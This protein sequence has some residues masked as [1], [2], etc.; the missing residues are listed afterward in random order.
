MAFTITQR[1]SN[2]NQTSSGESLTSSAFTPTANSRLFVIAVRMNDFHVIG[3]DWSISNTGS[4]SF[5]KLDESTGYP[6]NG[7]VNYVL[8]CVCWWDDIGGSPS[9]MTVTVQPDFSGGALHFISLIVF[10]VT[11]FDTGT[12][13]AQASVDNGSQKGGGDSESG[14]LTLGGSPTSGNLVV[15]MF[16]AGADTGGGFSTPTGYTSLTNQSHGYTQASTFYHTSTTT[17]AVNCSDLGNAVGNWGGIIFEMTAESSG[18]LSVSNIKIKEPAGLP[19][20][21]GIYDI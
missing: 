17:A 4:L 18:D 10:D 15:A 16:T 13:F 14:T 9:S 19:T 21:L 20:P 3:T 11:G 8:N 2:S 12:P 5:T 6:W 1:A 7:N